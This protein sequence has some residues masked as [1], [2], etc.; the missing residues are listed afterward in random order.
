MSIRFFASAVCLTALSL[1]TG[2]S[3]SSDSSD[4]GGPVAATPLQGEIDGKTFVAKSAIAEP[5]SSSDR[6]SI[7]VYDVDATCD[8]EPTNADRRILTSVPWKP[9]TTR[10]LKLDFADLN[11]SQTVTFVIGASN[12]IISNQGR[13]EVI[14]APTAKGDKGKIRIRATA[15]SHHVEGEIAVQVC[16]R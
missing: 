10:D 1:V 11:G 12:N 16:A 3:S 8:A 4:S 13:I 2:C 15:Q 5:G 6:M 14:D 9:G 7:T